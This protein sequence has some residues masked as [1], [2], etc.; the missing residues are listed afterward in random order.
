METGQEGPVCDRCREPVDPTD[1]NVVRAFERQEIKSFGVGTQKVDH[2]PGFFHR[3]HFPGGEWYRLLA[4]VIFVLLD[5]ERARVSEESALRVSNW[6]R[7]RTLDYVSLRK[8]IQEAIA[9]AEPPVLARL[10][11]VETA[12]VHELLGEMEK[13]E[14]P[15][16]HDLR[17]L[18]NAARRALALTGRRGGTNSSAPR[19]SR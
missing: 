15:L 16:P 13:Q 7:D 9:A 14:P 2:F 19:L 8:K 6:S 4:D 11:G 10:D 3:E 1:P 18:Q 17:E 12:L 5:R